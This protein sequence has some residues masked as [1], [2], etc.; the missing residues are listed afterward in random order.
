VAAGGVTD[1]E[2]GSGDFVAGD[3]YALGVEGHALVWDADAQNMGTISDAG[4]EGACEQKD[5]QRAEAHLERHGGYCGAKISPK[6]DFM[7]AQER[8]AE[9][10]W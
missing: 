4:A 10:S 3:F 7:A 6:N 2:L 9:G 1:S 5:H 8:F